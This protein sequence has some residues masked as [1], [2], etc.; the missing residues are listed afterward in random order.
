MGV[1]YKDKLEIEGYAN[2]DSSFVDFMQFEDASTKRNLAKKSFIGNSVYTPGYEYPKLDKLYDTD[3]GKDSLAHKKTKIYEAVLELEANKNGGVME[4]ELFELYAD[5]HELRLKRIMLV[6]AAQRVR[7]ASSSS[8]Q[9]TAREEFMFLNKELYGDMNR[10]WFNDIMSEEAECVES[11]EP[12]DEASAKIKSELL[13]YFR[14]HKFEA[15]RP[16]ES[17]FTAEEMMQLQETVHKRYATGLAEIP[18]TDDD[19]YYDAEEC[20]AILNRCLQ[21][22]GMAE[23]GWYVV[24]TQKKLIP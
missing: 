23:A 5:F 22:T 17:D 10:E 13:D 18:D 14:Q 8:E 12:K 2:V 6:E 9:A 19:V 4:P 16:G 24:L 15:R 3:E 7:T 11:F 20:A 1:T 21:A